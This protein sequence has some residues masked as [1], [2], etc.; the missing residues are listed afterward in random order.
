MAY[1][2]R[3][4]VKVR[5][6]VSRW[7]GGEGVRAA[8]TVGVPRGGAPPTDEQL[9]TIV[10]ARRP[11]R[12]TNTMAPSPELETLRPHEATIRQWLGE[13]LRLTKIHRRLRA[14]RVGVSYS[15]LHRFARTT[16]DFGRPALT[17]RIADPPPGGVAE[18]D[19]GVLGRWLDPTTGLGR[20]VCAV[21]SQSE[22]LRCAGAEWAHSRALTGCSGAPRLG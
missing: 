8:L 19:F 10:A 17:V 1:R 18:A 12:P 21:V 13:A 5:E 7:L 20:R 22:H 4:M 16:C 2:E 14:Q 3:G 9:T 15:A 6:M 11:G